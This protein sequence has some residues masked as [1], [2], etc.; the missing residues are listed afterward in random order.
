MSDEE[1]D[2]YVVYGETVLIAKA[3]KSMDSSE[4]L[5]AIP[6]NY[7]DQVPISFNLKSH[8]KIQSY[9]II[10]DRNSP[11]R[12][13]KVIL[14]P[15]EEDEEV[16]INFSYNVLIKNN[17]YKDLSRDTET[18]IPSESK[19]PEPV[20]IWLKPTK[21]IQ[22][23]NII[24]K[25]RAK[26]LK[27][28]D[29]SLL[30]LAK[31]IVFL[32]C[33]QRPVLTKIRYILESI[34]FL[35][36]IFLPKRYWTGLTDAFS[37]WMFGGL[38]VAQTNLAIALFRANGVPARIL[39]VNPLYY[40][41]REVDWID[42]LHYVI[43]F[44]VPKYGWIRANAG[45]APYQPKNDIALR[46]IYPEDENEAGNGLSYYG[47]M[48]PW[49]WFS[50]ENISLGFPEDLF[51]F[52]KKPKYSGVPITSKKVLNIFKLKIEDAEEAF[53][54][55]QENW[56]IFVKLFGK[57]MNCKAL[58]LQQKSTDF[59]TES[60]IEE[61]MKSIKESINYLKNIDQ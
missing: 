12:L 25:T 52:Y 35:R 15:L 8:P 41:S 27:R 42:A 19:L 53:K 56:E 47:G 1:K 59:I 33:Y 38:C 57:E 20:R 23:D 26:I 36:D 43:E 48:A 4:V 58:E 60:K 45:R 2:I 6:L 28:F 49:F 7:G 50:N 55:T 46:I 29:N 22:S 32:I 9:S 61:Y 13:L 11:N 44:Y 5:H 54:L 10:D 3:E 24:L 34:T 16:R 17:K 40:R 51:T 18:E 21:S 30:K 39:I 31:K 37:A 14:R